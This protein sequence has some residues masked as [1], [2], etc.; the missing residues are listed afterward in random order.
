MSGEEFSRRDF[1]RRFAALSSAAALVRFTSG[2]GPV[3]GG[4][5]YGPP[6]VEVGTV[7]VTGSYFLD[8]QSNRVLL[9]DSAAVPVSARFQLTFSGDVRSELF[10]LSF[11]DAGNVTIPSDIA[12]L[13]LRTVEITPRGALSGATRYSLGVSRGVDSS[14]RLLVSQAA[15]QF[16]TLP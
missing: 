5:V 8:S 16:T 13:D 11:V 1:L 12:W 7:T 15:A 4:A 6:F 2:C 14:G 3:T 10:E 9:N